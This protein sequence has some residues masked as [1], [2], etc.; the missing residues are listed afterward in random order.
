MF[1]IPFMPR[2]Y[3]PAGVP[4]PGMATITVETPSG[5]NVWAD[6]GDP[7][8]SVPQP[9]DWVWFA[10]V[11][12]GQN[13]VRHSANVRASVPWRVQSVSDARSGS[14]VPC[15]DR[16]ILIQMANGAPSSLV[17]P[18]PGDEYTA[19]VG[20]YESLA[21]ALADCTATP[22]AG[23]AGQTAIAVGAGLISAAGLLYLISKK[24]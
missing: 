11:N 21:R 1:L 13:R 19:V 14:N 10:K 5:F 23:T 18:Q 2:G 15:V 17:T 7:D 6:H 4:S 22:S 9:T 20:T 24:G 3:R 8:T 12:V 16:V